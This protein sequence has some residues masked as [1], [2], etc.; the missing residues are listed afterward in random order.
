MLQSSVYLCISECSCTELSVRLTYFRALYISVFQNVRVQ[1]PRISELC[2]F[3]S[4]CTELTYFRAL[5]R[6]CSRVL[7][8]APYTSI[9]R[10]SERN[11]E[12]W[13]TWV[14]FRMLVYRAH[15]FQSS[16]F[17][18]CTESSVHEHSEIHSRISELCISL[19]FSENARVES[20]L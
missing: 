5:S 16:V 1:S 13:N 19:W 14:Y 17:Q 11:T 12:L 7:Q 4:S 8:R 10:E 15:V 18:S 2:V 6:E 9:L 3:R 20:S